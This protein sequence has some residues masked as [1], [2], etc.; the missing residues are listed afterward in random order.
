MGKSDRENYINLLTDAYKK[1]MDVA[2]IDPA[3]EDVE[4]SEMVDEIP[5]EDR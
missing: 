1:I 4:E 5:K 3:T 2:F